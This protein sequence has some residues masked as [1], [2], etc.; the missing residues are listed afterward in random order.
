MNKTEFTQAEY[1]SK[2]FTDLSLTD[3]Q[4]D[5]IE[6]EDCSF[7]GCDFSGA[8]F[9]NCCFIDC[10]FLGCNLSLVNLGFSRF[11][12][13]AFVESKLI[14]INWSNAT[15]PSYA[16][17]API[18]FKQCILN[19]S[20]FIGLSLTDLV[21]EDCKAHHV[22]FRDSDLSHALFTH[23]D[24][25]HARFGKTNLTNADFSD[26][27]NYNI[28]VMNN[29]IKGAIFCRFEAVSLL[30]SLGIELVD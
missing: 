8:M 15:W 4:I 13:V 22:D 7:E 21:M 5:N 27:L 26:A 24:F 20:T 10:R 1:F 9:K 2:K 19:D 17:S 6:F 12:D 11:N 18:E 14:G 16:L 30:E 29:R 25:S 23:T 3:A 28:D